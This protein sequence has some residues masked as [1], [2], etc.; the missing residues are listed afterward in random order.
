MTSEHLKFEEVFEEYLLITWRVFYVLGKVKTSTD[1]LNSTLYV[2][3]IPISIV[4]NVL[5]VVLKHINEELEEMFSDLV[6][7]IVRESLL[8]FLLRFNNVF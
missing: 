1:S 4:Y 5:F 6:N 7:L 8:F 2:E 3:N